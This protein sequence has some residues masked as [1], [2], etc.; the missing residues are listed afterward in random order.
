MPGFKVASTFP[1]FLYRCRV[2]L[3]QP[4]LVAF[5]S[6]IRSAP[7]TAALPIGL[8]GF[9]WGGKFVFLLCSPSADHDNDE[10]DP[11]TKKPLI[12]CGF[13]AHPSNLALPEDAE[14]VTVPMSV[15]AG[16]EDVVLGMGEVAKIQNAFKLKGGVEKGFEVVVVDGAKHGFAV[17]GNPEK[18]DEAKVSCKQNFYYCF[19]LPIIPCGLFCPSVCISCCNSPVP[20]IG[21]WRLLERRVRWWYSSSSLSPSLSLSLSLWPIFSLANFLGM[22]DTILYSDS[23]MLP[24][25]PEPPKKS[26]FCDFLKKTQHCQKAEDQAVNWFSKW[27]R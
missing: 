19:R 12:D 4:R 5:L 10:K 17:R 20:K 2:S 9:C 23:Q 11:S 14:S 6:S 16:S 15:S 3:V 13:T 18:E 22:L 1:I 24:H 27:L 8:A 25:K 26:D 21:K 7:G